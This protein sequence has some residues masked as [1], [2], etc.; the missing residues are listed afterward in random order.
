MRL[1]QERQISSKKDVHTSMEVRVAASESSHTSAG[2]RYKIVVDNVGVALAVAVA[3]NITAT[4]APVVDN[5]CG[6]CQSI[7]S[8]GPTHN[9]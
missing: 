1:K 3:R 9:W 4:A 7:I 2:P 5:L 6:K 8:S